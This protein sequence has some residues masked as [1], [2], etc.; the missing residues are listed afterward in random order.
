MSTT[1]IEEQEGK[2][3]VTLLIEMFLNDVFRR[4]SRNRFV[5]RFDRS[6]LRSKGAKLLN[7]E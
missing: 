2:H 4:F 7:N 6:F 1:W 3:T 5:G